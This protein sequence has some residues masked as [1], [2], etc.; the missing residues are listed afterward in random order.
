M[1]HGAKG[2]LGIQ[3]LTLAA[4][5]VPLRKERSISVGQYLD[6][7]E[8]VCFD[9]RVSPTVPTKHDCVRIQGR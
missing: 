6:S 7:S 8:V 3:R 1:Q 4:K 9:P 5:L 2:R